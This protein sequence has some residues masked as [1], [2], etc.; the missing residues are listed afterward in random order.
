MFLIVDKSNDSIHPRAQLGLPGKLVTITQLGRQRLV[1]LGLSETMKRQLLMLKKKLL[2]V[3]KNIP[4]MYNAYRDATDPDLGRTH[5]AD[6]DNYRVMSPEEYALIEP[7]ITKTGKSP[8][9]AK[10]L[11]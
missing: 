9:M 5:L 6:R 3:R 2:M 4:R 8:T 1:L 7:T 11:L 10:K